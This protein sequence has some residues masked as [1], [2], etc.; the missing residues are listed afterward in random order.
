MKKVTL[1]LSFILTIFSINAFAE[2]DSFYEEFSQPY[3]NSWDAN[4]KCQ[5]IQ[6]LEVFL[7]PLIT[8]PINDVITQHSSK[9]I[10]KKQDL[11]YYIPEE[12]LI[13]LQT[14]IIL[15]IKI[16]H[17]LRVCIMDYLN[18]NG[19][20]DQFLTDS[21]IQVSEFLKIGY[22]LNNYLIENGSPILQSS[23]VR[24]NSADS[25]INSIIHQT[26]LTHQ[27]TKIVFKLVY[28]QAVEDTQGPHKTAHIAAHLLEVFSH[29]II[30]HNEQMYPI[31]SKQLDST[32]EPKKVISLLV[33][34]A[35]ERQRYYQIKINAEI[36]LEKIHSQMLQNQTVKNTKPLL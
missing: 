25:F 22:Y 23:L 10:M 31:I 17:A 5:V 16:K 28:N 34:N 30:K 32:K 9:G 12:K 6:Y 24:F 21:S 4:L 20:Y 29:N 11:F 3:L 36:I 33:Q 35:S 15:S 7:H 14:K 26:K 19:K 1:I 27:D 8:T 13:D 18:Q 2:K